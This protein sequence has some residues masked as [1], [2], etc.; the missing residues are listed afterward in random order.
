M[1][2]SNHI[3]VGVLLPEAN[4]GILLEMNSKKEIRVL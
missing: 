4:C 1:Y 3:H 2:K